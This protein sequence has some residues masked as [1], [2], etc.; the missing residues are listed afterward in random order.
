M[1]V[2]LGW[3]KCRAEQKFRVWLTTWPRHFHFHKM[4]CLIYG[5]FILLDC[6]G[7]K[8]NDK[9]KTHSPPSI[10]KIYD[11]TELVLEMN[12]TVDH[13]LR[14]K[15][16]VKIWRDKSTKYIHTIKYLKTIDLYPQTHYIIILL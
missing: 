12:S 8:N 9:D 14:S 1:C 6:C 15:N 10:K 3:V 7:K 4:F 13:V 11:F 5:L 16:H 2:H